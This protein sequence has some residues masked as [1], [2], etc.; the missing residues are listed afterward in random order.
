[1]Q[2]REPIIESTARKPFCFVLMPF[3][4]KLNDVYS[5]GIKPACEEAGFD[6]DRVD[7]QFV[8]DRI[9][10]K[11]LCQIAEADLIIADMSGSNAN[12]FYEVGYAHGIERRP[13]LLI[14][15]EEDIPFHLK[16]YQHIIYSSIESLKHKL[17]ASIRAHIALASNKNEIK[18]KLQI[19]RD[20]TPL[21]ENKNTFEFVR[22][23]A[24]SFTLVLHNETETTFEPQLYGIGVDFPSVFQL[25]WQGALYPSAHSN[26][27]RSS[28][29]LHYK[30]S[31]FPDDRKPLSFQFSY[32]PTGSEALLAEYDFQLRLFSHLGSRSYN[33]SIKFVT[34]HA[35]GI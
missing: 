1:M 23:E 8:E 26:N 24:P 34:Q 25:V 17:I 13:I 32:F 29:T 14:S 5:F 27:G 4:Q 2:E 3:S 35:S 12:V 21:E 20:G 10:D 28:V 22:G 16:D 33:C 15:A 31:L 9:S 7:Q 11:I 18:T 6:C 19:L 30:N